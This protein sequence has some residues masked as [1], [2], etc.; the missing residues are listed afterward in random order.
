MIKLSKT[1]KTH[2]LGEPQ[3]SPIREKQTELKDKI[4]PLL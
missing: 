4:R 2:E 3:K 1:L